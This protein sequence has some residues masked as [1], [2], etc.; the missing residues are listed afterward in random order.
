MAMFFIYAL[1]ASFV[2]FRLIICFYCLLS[3]KVI[4]QCK[5]IIYEPLHID[6]WLNP[7]VHILY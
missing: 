5:F 7:Y 1:K 3:L 4:K 6:K 2:Q